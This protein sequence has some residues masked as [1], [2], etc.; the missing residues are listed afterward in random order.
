MQRA[1]WK[2]QLFENYQAAYAVVTE[3][4]SF[5]NQH[6]IHGSLYHLTP[7]QFIRAIAN[8]EGNPLFVKP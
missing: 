7:E 1:L 8:H 4:I 2:R 5:Y 3:Y 6:R